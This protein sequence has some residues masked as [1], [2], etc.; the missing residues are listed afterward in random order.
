MVVWPPKWERFV[1]RWMF[2]SVKNINKTRG[3]DASFLVVFDP[4]RFRSEGLRASASERV[5]L[6][7]N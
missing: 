1:R 2:A 3:C 5:C 6:P 4:M 7:L